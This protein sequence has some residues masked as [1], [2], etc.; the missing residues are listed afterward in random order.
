[1]IVNKTP[2]E[3]ILYLTSTD[4]IS[5]NSVAL[6]YTKNTGLTK[7]F[8]KSFS[9]SEDENEQIDLTQDDG[10]ISPQSKIDDMIS[11]ID[12]ILSNKSLA[13]EELLL[14]DE[15]INF[16]IR[17]GNTTPEKLSQS[18]FDDFDVLI[19]GNEDNI[20]EE[21][22]LENSKGKNLLEESLT[23][24]L[25]ISDLDE[26]PSTRKS[27]EFKRFRSETQFNRSDDFHYPDFLLDE[28]EVDIVPTEEPENEFQ[29]PQN[30][31]I[32][33]L[34]KTFE[35]EYEIETDLYTIKTKNVQ[36]K[37]DYK[38]MTLAQLTEELKKFGLKKLSRQ[39]AVFILDHIY[40]QTHPVFN[41]INGN[42]FIEEEKKTKTK[43]PKRKVVKKK[44]SSSQPTCSKYLD[45]EIN[46]L[47][48]N[49]EI[50]PEENFSANLLVDD[51][52]C[53]EIENEEYFL[54]SKP[55]GKMNSCA[56]PVHIAFYN[57]A[58]SDKKLRE[59]ILCYEPINL[60]KLYL[61]FKGIGLRYEP[62]VSLCFLF[63]NSCLIFC[64]F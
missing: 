31:V 48:Q 35:T 39:R 14:S 28:E 19:H 7:I 62:N 20:L 2:D 26:I 59:S 18:D 30:K 36:S 42:L 57:K 1:M 21:S 25:N 34:S 23:E 3:E 13:E 38:N 46:E 32:E 61:F 47:S 56:V 11:K 16:S 51:G 22:I 44:V 50:S 54:P 4:A 15:E 63:F 17:K 53:A 5:L 60:D 45:L 27:K 29:I 41:E 33:F 55:R 12:S 52:T 24:I 43:S 37:P 58:K 40:K 8:E 6:T 49:T 10:V 64:L 9:F